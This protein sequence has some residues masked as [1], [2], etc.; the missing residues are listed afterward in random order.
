VIAE[1]LGSGGTLQQVRF[2]LSQRLPLFVIDQGQFEADE[3]LEGYRTL[4]SMGAIPANSPEIVAD[5]LMG[6]RM[7][8]HPVVSPAK[9]SDRSIQSRLTTN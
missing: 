1:Y 3:V 5:W 6:R 7:T 8:P 9:R 2:A 4:V